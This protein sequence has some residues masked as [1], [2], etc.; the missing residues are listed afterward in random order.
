MKTHY[1]EADLLETYYTQPG[2]SM[3][4]MMHLAGCADCAGRYE[5]LDRKLREA[6]SC[7]PAPPESFWHRQRA[8]IVRR[9][10]EQRAHQT[11]I[12]RAARF[13]AAACLMFILGGLAVYKALE[14]SPVALAPVAAPVSAPPAAALEPPPATN[15]DPWQSDEL[16]DFHSVVEWESWVDSRKED[17]S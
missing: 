3:P 17:R 6:A 14:P 7:T 11:W 12:T 2:E 15:A 4:V 10:N 5:R 8:T 9:A 1:S 13:A 16:K